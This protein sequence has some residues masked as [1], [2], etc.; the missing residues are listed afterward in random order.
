MPQKPITSLN[1][2]VRLLSFVDRDVQ[3]S[4]KSNV[5][6]C[7]HTATLVC[8]DSNESLSL[9][10][11]QMGANARRKTAYKLFKVMDSRGNE[12]TRLPP[13]VYYPLRSALRIRK[14]VSRARA[15]FEAIN[16]V[17]KVK[18]VILDSEPAKTPARPRIVATPQPK[19]PPSEAKVETP[20][21]WED[22]DA[23][24]KAVTPDCWDD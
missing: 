9:A 14:E 8:F 22:D 15:F 3:R 16:R 7:K 11:T 24:D 1:A 18:I 23:V 19:P 5:G 13:D 2:I 20:D 4:L 17:G 12:V 6:T 10:D 21:S